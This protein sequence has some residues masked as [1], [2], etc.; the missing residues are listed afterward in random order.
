MVDVI[1]NLVAA[2]IGAVAAYGYSRFRRWSNDRIVRWFWM[3]DRFTKIVVVVG[4]HPPASPGA[5]EVE[6]MI[7][8]MDALTLGHLRL[9]LQKHFTEVQVTTSM[10][11]IDWSCPVVSVGGPLANALTSTL[12]QSLPLWFENLPY[13]PGDSRGISTRDQRE[14]YRSSFNADGS[15]ATDVGFVARLRSS[16]DSRAPIIVVAGNYGA[17]TQGVCKLLTDPVGLRALREKV[18]GDDAFFQAL[19]R[20][21]VNNGFPVSPRVTT[22]HE[23]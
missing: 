4:H 9:F 5:G 11:Q 15:L 12:G 8:I 20:T 1:L 23:V 17:G 21:T 2:A 16:K 7:N 22:T 3:S 18:T 14:V 10:D 13:K 6:G 19:V